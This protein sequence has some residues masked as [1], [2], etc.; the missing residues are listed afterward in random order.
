MELVPELVQVQ[1]PEPERVLELVPVPEQ[2]CSS[3]R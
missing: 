2:G 3:S 1:E